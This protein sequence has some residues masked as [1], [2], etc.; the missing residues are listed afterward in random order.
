MPELCMMD[1]HQ[2]NNLPKVAFSDEGPYA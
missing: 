2:V 1:V